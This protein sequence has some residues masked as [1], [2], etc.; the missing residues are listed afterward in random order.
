MPS[1]IQ[2]FIRTYMGMAELQQG[3]QQIEQRQREAQI[4]GLNTFISLARQTA[5]PTQLTSLA[6]RFAQLGVA[7]I[8]HLTSILGSITPDQNALDAHAQQRGMMA[9]EG[10]PT[11]ETASADATYK[12][13][14]E[15]RITGQT[16]GQI[17]ADNL[18]ALFLNRTPTEGAAGDVMAAAVQARQLGGTTPGQ[19]V[20]DNVLSNLDRATLDWGARASIGTALTQGQYSQNELGWANLRQQERA[21]LGNQAL[22]EAQLGLQKSMA[23][24]RNVGKNGEQVPDP[25]NIASLISTKASIL[26]ELMSSKETPTPALMM[27]YIGALNGINQQ[28]RLGGV[29]TEAPIEYKPEMLTD[30][31]WFESFKRRNIAVAPTPVYPNPDRPQHA[32]VQAGR[33]R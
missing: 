24:A 11:G 27:N 4:A 28:L 12:R 13:G 33:P 10:N 29:P 31:N 3:Q 32:P 25:S 6:Q 18:N 21:T 19:L 9:I 17:A 30:P 16:A 1:S 2:D 7:P 23:D 15:N 8:E 22:Q 14:A 5:D 20:L 26:R